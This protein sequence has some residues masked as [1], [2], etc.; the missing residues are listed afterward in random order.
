MFETNCVKRL[1]S[2]RTLTLAAVGGTCLTLTAGPAFGDPDDW[3]A[4]RGPNSGGLAATA[5]PPLEISPTN[6]VLWIADV[7]WSPSSPCIAGGRVFLTTFADGKLET[8][9][10]ATQ[11]GKLL[12]SRVAPAETLEQYHPTYGSPAAATPVSDGQRVVSYFG[13]CGL[14]CYDAAEGR[15][16]WRHPLP[17]AKTHGN[18]GSGTSPVLAGNRVILNRDLL[19]G[20]AIF[21]LNAETGVQLWETARP[22]LPT[23]YSTPILWNHDGLSELIVAGSLHLRA[24]DPGTGA[25]RWRVQ[26]LPSAACT[27]PVLGDGWLYFAGWS[28]GKADAPFPT[29]EMLVAKFDKDGDGALSAAETQGDMVWLQSF[30]FDKNGKLEKTEWDQVTESIK[31]GDNSLMAIKPGG[32]GDVTGSHVAW[33]AAKGLPYVPSPLFYQGRVYLVKDGGLISSFD[34]KTGEPAYVQERLTDAAG[35]YYASPV[36]AAKRIYLVSLKGKLTVVKAGGDKPVI[37][38]QADFGEAIDATPALVGDR[39]YLRTRT[40]LLAFG[41]R[42]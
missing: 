12:W 25:E 20:S 29:W 3:P 15:E 27:T 33:K 40:K 24:Y 18:F 6:G 17:V 28:P 14:F 2:R 7:P 30:D 36:A 41:P 9:A 22:E 39:I 21:A 23:S 42:Q 38:H 8:R 34:A 31:R 4:F 37:L 11:N 1:F 10:Y 35:T 5:R 19:A 26:G 13:S 16:L 32:K